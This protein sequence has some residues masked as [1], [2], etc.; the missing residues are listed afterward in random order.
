VKQLD[1]GA[2]KP[3]PKSTKKKPAAKKKPARRK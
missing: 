1:G 3:T 2:A